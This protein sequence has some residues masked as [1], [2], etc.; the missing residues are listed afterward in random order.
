MWIYLLDTV[1]NQSTQAKLVRIAGDLNPL[2][3]ALIDDILGRRGFRTTQRTDLPVEAIVINGW[4][5]LASNVAAIVRAAREGLPVI[6]STA[7]AK[8]T[9]TDVMIAA[10]ARVV[11][12]PNGI[13]TLAFAVHDEISAA[14]A[15]YQRCA[16]ADPP[17]RAIS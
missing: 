11:R 5:C 8:R 3:V 16:W 15:Q 13:L 9:D 1:M 12:K 17:L 6:V 10:G 4:N 2:D 14:A 7:M